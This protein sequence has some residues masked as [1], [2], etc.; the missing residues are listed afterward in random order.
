MAAV[1]ASYPLTMIFMAIAVGSQIGVTVEVSRIFGSK[2]IGKM[3]TVIS[4]SLIATV[5]LSIILSVLGVAFSRSMLQLLSTPENIFKDSKTYLD[6]YF[7]GFVF[8]YVYN[9]VTGAFHSLGNSRTPLYFLI[10]SSIGNVLLDLLFVITFQWGVAGAAIATLLSQGIAAIL[11]YACLHGQLKKLVSKTKTEWFRLKA[12]GRVARVAIPSILQQSFVSVGNLFIQ[13]LV[14]GYGSSVIAGYSAAIKINTFAITGFATMGNGISGFCA[15]NIGAGKPQRL[16]EG[17]KAGLRNTIVVALIFSALFF[18]FGEQLLSL[19]MNENSKELAM[20]T[21]VRFLRI[22]SPFYLIV[23]FKLTADGVLRGSQRMVQFM[24]A[25]FSDLILR[26][27]FAFVLSS[28]LQVDGIWLSWP[29]GWVIAA[30]MSMIFCI[31]CLRHEISR[32][33]QK[34]E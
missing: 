6:I 18:F 30:I 7:A 25:T 28:Y 23:S 29:I 20:E 34:N 1:G 9:V 24:V 14:N 5:L 19:F 11:S 3:K 13:E 21:G 33:R 16:K 4:T 10:C 27:V 12:L 8:V 15:Q 32:E 26:V 31:L 2:D 17:F 22:V